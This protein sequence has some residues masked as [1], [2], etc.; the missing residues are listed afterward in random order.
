MDILY[1]GTTVFIAKEEYM[2]HTN[3]HSVRR[4]SASVP[5]DGAS[6]YI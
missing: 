2:Q 4:Q 1:K 6:N 3:R 5:S